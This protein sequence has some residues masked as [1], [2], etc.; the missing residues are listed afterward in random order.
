LEA[1]RAPLDLGAPATIGMHVGTIHLT[2]E[3]LDDP[4]RALHA[5]LHADGAAPDR[6]RVLDFGESISL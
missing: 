4:V 2:T 1:V 6:F 3:G 5:A